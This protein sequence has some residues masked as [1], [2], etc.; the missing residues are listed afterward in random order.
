MKVNGEIG[1]KKYQKGKL[2]GKGI[3]GSKQAALQNATKA[4]TSKLKSC[5][6]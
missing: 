4:P 1:Y 6:Q 5:A 2:R 3:I